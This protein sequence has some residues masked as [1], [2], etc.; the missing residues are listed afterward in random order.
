MRTTK[1]TELQKEKII[2]RIEKNLGKKI[3][4]CE[5]AELRGTI[6][7]VN[8]IGI[9]PKSG[10]GT[11]WGLILFCQAENDRRDLYFY[12]PATE[13]MF[14]FFFRQNSGDAPAEDQFICLNDL[15]NL[16]FETPKKS[17]F[18]F[19][20]P[21][22][23]RTIFATANVKGEEVKF[24]FLLMENKAEEVAEKLRTF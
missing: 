19:L 15:E 10:L 23:K 20:N 7:A 11:A 24:Y 2:Q 9:Y 5:L 12:Y 22:E 4:S 1:K 8:K 21:D 6:E 3:E 13:G 14:D 17:F 18:S 16:T